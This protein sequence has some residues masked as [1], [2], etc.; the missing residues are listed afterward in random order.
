M[1]S[2]PNHSHIDI[3]QNSERADGPEH[4][5]AELEDIQLSLE[6]ITTERVSTKS[7]RTQIGFMSGSKDLEA[8]EQCAMKEYI[9][10]SLLNARRCGLL[11]LPRPAQLP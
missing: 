8:R 7:S 11:C 1:S 5:T 4:H 3:A 10:T 2:S 9:N 6:V